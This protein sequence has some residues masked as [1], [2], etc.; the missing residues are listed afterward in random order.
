MEGGALVSGFFPLQS[1]I[2]G[3]LFYSAASLLCGFALY[4]IYSLFGLDMTWCI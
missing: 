3:F 4:M 2:G 1:V